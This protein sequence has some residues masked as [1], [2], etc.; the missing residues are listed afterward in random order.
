YVRLR[1]RPAEFAARAA[2]VLGQVPAY[3][4]NLGYNELVRTN[5][6]ARLLLQ[7]ASAD[8]LDDPAGLR[9]LL[10]APEIHGQGL[11]LRRL[12]RGDDR[13]RSLAAA[14]LDLLRATLLRPLHRGT[15]RLAFR[16]LLN[17]ATTADN[18]RRV[19]GRARE[20]L[21][22]PDK[23]YPKEQLIGL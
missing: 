23:G 5:R 6:L 13:A 16:A 18:A 14:N 2:N 9:D 15:R 10:E 12:G 21:D 11:A 22:L 4:I 1:A 7:R 3:S 17:A 8:H 20:A 19:L